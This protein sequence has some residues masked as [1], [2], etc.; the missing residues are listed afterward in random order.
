MFKSLFTS[1]EDKQQRII[2]YVNDPNTNLIDLY[3]I[4]KSSTKPKNNEV[5]D[6]DFSDKKYKDMVIN[7]ILK[8]LRF[9]CIKTEGIIINKPDTNYFSLEVLLK[10][11]NVNYN[12]TK[13]NNNDYYNVNDKNSFFK[14]EI[15]SVKY[16][17][18]L[19][20]N[21]QE[22]LSIKFKKIGNL[23]TLTLKDNEYVFT[24]KN[25]DN[26]ENSEN[27]TTLYSSDENPT[28]DHLF[29][30]TTFIQILNEIEESKLPKPS[31]YYCI[32]GR[33]A[34]GEK[35]NQNI[36]HLTRNSLGSYCGG[37]TKKNKE[38]QGK[39]RKT[40]EKQGKTRKN[41][42]T[43]SLTNTTYLKRRNI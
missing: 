43:P 8:S 29:D 18:F 6:I 26:S 15:G 3:L 2:K 42:E 25:S 16:Y 10:D 13:T 28:W 7:A 24:F 20:K 32:T 39:P 19:K 41:K 22:D 36:H 9:I 40:K 30:Q 37:K 17:I 12:D 31:N 38:N 11:N 23:I 1:I 35:Y 33:L 34:K 14:L 5:K 21:I 4:I 27:I